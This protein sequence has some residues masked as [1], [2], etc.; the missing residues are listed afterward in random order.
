MKKFNLLIATLLFSYLC[1]SPMGIANPSTTTTPAQVSPLQL[2]QVNIN[3]ATAEQ[4]QKTLIGIGSK[5]AEAIV[6]YREKFGAFTAPEQLLEVSGFGKA[7][8][9]KNRE[10]IVLE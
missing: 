4:L 6:Q 2:N 7:T 8:L 5:K 10:R 3:T 9:E 1:F